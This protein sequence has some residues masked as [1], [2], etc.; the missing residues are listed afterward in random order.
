MRFL[1]SFSSYA[2][3]T[4]SFIPI[5]T[6]VHTF[7][8]FFSN[9]HNFSFLLFKQVLM[10]SLQSFPW[11]YLFVPGCYIR[12]GRSTD[13]ATPG[14]FLE[15]DNVDSLE[16]CLQLWFIILDKPVLKSRRAP[17]GCFFLPLLCFYFLL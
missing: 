14:A 10:N 15:K 16:F 2:V 11:L 12:M 5:L 17:C 1:S 3:L 13:I 4:L 6:P 7:V 9:G 8:G